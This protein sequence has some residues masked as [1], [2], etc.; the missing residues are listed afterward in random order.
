MNST[1]SYILSFLLFLSPFS[2]SFETATTT[3]SWYVC[4]IRARL[5]FHCWTAIIFNEWCSI[6]A[7][8]QTCDNKIWQ[9]WC[10]VISNLNIA[11]T[12]LGNSN[13]HNNGAIIYWNTPWIICFWIFRFKCIELWLPLGYKYNSYISIAFATRIISLISNWLE[14]CA[15]EIGYTHANQMMQQLMHLIQSLAENLVQVYMTWNRYKNF[16]VKICDPN[17]LKSNEVC[18]L[19]KF[20]AVF[21]TRA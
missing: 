2:F 12:S 10:S 9:F 21:F 18:R 15:R 13:K 3:K 4:L 20:G 5:M 8:F 7:W 11:A 16:I 17:A 1:V 6:A 19:V 14:N